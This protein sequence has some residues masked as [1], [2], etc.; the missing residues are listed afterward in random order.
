M[1]MVVKKEGMRKERGGVCMYEQWGSVKGVVNVSSVS[2]GPVRR[3][4]DSGTMAA[5]SIQKHSC[6]EC[7]HGF[8]FPAHGKLQL[9]THMAGVSHSS[10]HAHTR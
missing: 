6:C 10:E 4:S 2:P 9:R 7:M 1:E 8:V 5:G 3:V